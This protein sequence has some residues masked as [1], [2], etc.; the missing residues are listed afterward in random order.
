M[1]DAVPVAERCYHCSFNLHKE[2]VGFLSAIVREQATR[3]NEL[4]KVVTRDNDVLLFHLVSLRVIL[5][6]LKVWG[7]VRRLTFHKRANILAETLY[8]KCSRDNVSPFT[9]AS[10]ICSVRKQSVSGTVQK[11]VLFSFPQQLLLVCAKG[12]H[13]GNKTFPNNVS[14]TVFFRLT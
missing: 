10:N 4:Y 7:K 12:E 13:Q 2:D 5:R 8:V 11:H 14:S 9:R 6:K 3:L 1:C